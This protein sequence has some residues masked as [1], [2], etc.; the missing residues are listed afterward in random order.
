MFLKPPVG[1]KNLG[2]V[3]FYVALSCDAPTERIVPGIKKEFRFRYYPL[4]IKRRHPKMSKELLTFLIV[5]TLSTTVFG[6]VRDPIQRARSASVDAAVTV[7]RPNSGAIPIVTSTCAYTFTSG[8]TGAQQYLQY[9]VTVNGNIV[10]FQSPAGSEHIRLGIFGDGYA[11]CDFAGRQVGY[12]DYADYG[13]TDTGPGWGQPVL[14][15][16]TA[17]AVKIA[18]TTLDG[19]WTLTQTFTQN[20]PDASVRVA[21]AIK[22]QTAIARYVWLTRFTDI[23]ANNA[24]LNIMD[25]TKRGVFGYDT[26]KTGHGL[27]ISLEGANQNYKVGF[28]TTQVN[29]ACVVGRGY[30]GLLNDVDG[31]TYYLNGINVP[32]HGTKSLTLKYKGF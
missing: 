9:C 31:A 18:R 25:G 26:S 19:I 24:F 29:N 30:A 20:A 15:S 1:S 17:T 22:N 4:K 28:A 12:H 16:Q 14:L 6:Q 27:Q 3:E 8:G 5:A 10:E 7:S 11:L 2:N 13:D 21:M 32:A 23:D